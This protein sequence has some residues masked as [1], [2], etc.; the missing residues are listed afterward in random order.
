MNALFSTTTR[1]VKLTTQTIRES[2][3]KIPLNRI[4]QELNN[5]I[6]LWVLSVASVLEIWQTCVNALPNE[7][8]RSRAAISWRPSKRKYAGVTDRNLW[9]NHYHWVIVIRTPWNIISIASHKFGKRS[10]INQTE[11]LYAQQVI[12]AWLLFKLRVLI[13]DYIERYCLVHYLYNLVVIYT[14]H[15]F[16]ELA[17]WLRI[18]S[19]ERQW[20]YLNIRGE[21]IC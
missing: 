21:K 18:C 13:T 8:G 4:G 9:H 1:I 5:W 20:K 3:R 6:Q 7:A 12:R 2:F 15:V 19:E 17:S 11:N 16:G 10:Y 14:R